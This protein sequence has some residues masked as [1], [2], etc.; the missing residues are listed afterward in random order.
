MR[1]WSTAVL[2]AVVGCAS[3]GEPPAVAPEPPTVAADQDASDSEPDP[4]DEAEPESESAAPDP[5]V[6][7]ASEET[8][9]ADTEARPAGSP[10]ILTAGLSGAG[11]YQWAAR[12]RLDKD[13]RWRGGVS[14]F[15]EGQRD[16]VPTELLQPGQEVARLGTALRLGRATFAIKGNYFPA[17]Q[18]FA[19]QFE[20]GVLVDLVGKYDLPLDKLGLKLEVFGGGNAEWADDWSNLAFVGAR[21]ALT[22]QEIAP[23]APDIGTLNLLGIG[24]ATVGGTRYRSSVLGLALYD[25]PKG[26]PAGLSGLYALYG[27]ATAAGHGTPW[28]RVGYSKAY[29][30]TGFKKGVWTKHVLGLGWAYPIALPQHGRLTEI[31]VGA[32]YIWGL[33]DGFRGPKGSPR[34]AAPTAYAGGLGDLAFLVWWLE[35][36]FDLGKERRREP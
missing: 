16:F 32:Q 25:M 35:F 22:L 31:Y 15:A 27:Y 30:V 23:N 7:D 21:R 20:H 9:D 17:N 5:A 29:E 28:G 34:D 18:P 33:D 10:A 8:D 36:R 11:V 24:T 4:P 3:F 6:S 12:A 13:F 1:Y 14:V 19:E 26:L 2:S